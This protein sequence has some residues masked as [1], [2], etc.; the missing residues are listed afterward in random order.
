MINFGPYSF[1]Q[2]KVA[3]VVDDGYSVELAIQL[4]EKFKKVYY[5]CEW[6]IGYTIVNEYYIGR[7]IQQI[8][9]IDGIFDYI[10]DIDIFIFTSILQG[11]L[12][13][14]LE[15][16]GKLVYGSRKAEILELDRSFGKKILEQLDLPVVSYKIIRGTEALHQ[17]LQEH[18]D[19][20][21]KID[22]TFR[23]IAET[24]HSENYALSELW[25]DELEGKLGAVGDDF[26]F[27]VEDNIPDSIETGM[28]LICVNGQYSR[29]NLVGIEI[30]NKVYL[31]RIMN[32]FDIPE[33]ITIISDTLSPIFRTYGFRGS[34]SDEIRITKDL[35]SYMM[36]FT[37][38]EP[39][40]PQYLRQYM[41]KNLPEMIYKATQGQVIEPEFEKEYG[42]ELLLQSRTNEKNFLPVFIPDQYRKNVKLNH[43]MMKNDIPHITPNG[44][45]GS[46]VAGGDTLEEAIEKVEEIVQEIKGLDIEYDLFALKRGQEEI[47]KMDKFGINFF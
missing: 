46:V 38:R 23:G 5:F 44:Y 10:K 1:L 41:F 27:L 7:N 18:E 32:R 42:C 6:K 28:D 12:Q 29:Y 35:K 13:C 47:K 24:W 20:W 36:D 26:E 17:Y 9:R 19:V 22:S 2:D 15:A 34:Y 30:K 45:V 14:Y 43:I 39:T 3:C 4:S 33:Q 37:M 31:G 16:Q 25:I 40:P 11:D 21:V 8:E